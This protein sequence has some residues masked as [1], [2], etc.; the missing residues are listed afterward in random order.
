L[1]RSSAGGGRGG[2]P[3]DAIVVGAGHNGLVCATYLARAGLRTVVLERRAEAGGALANHELV[4]GA[5]VPALA[6]TV[7]R[8]RPSVVRDLDLVRHGLRLVQP[9]ARV[10][11]VRPDG[12]PITLWGDPVRTAA[13]IAPFSEHD[14]GA[15]A[16]LDRQVR[17]HAGVMDRL[18][19]MTPPDPRSPQPGVML[20]A[21]RVGLGYRSLDRSERREFVRVLPMAVLDFLGDY[22]DSDALTAAVAV[23]G[24]RF[25]SLGPRSTGSV[26]QLLAD[27]AGNGGGLAG[28]TV[29]ARGGPSSVTSALIAALVEHGGELRT[30]AE[31]SLVRE[32]DGRVAGVTLASGDELDAPLVVGAVDP[33][34]LLCDLVDPEVLG[35]H[36]GWQA[37]NLRQ[38]GVTA[39]VN[40]ALS[41]LPRF[42]GIDPEQNAVRLR[43]RILV[44]PSV[45]YLDDA[46]DVAKHGRFPTD[47]WLE[48]TI[49]SLVDPLLVDGARDSGV[50]HVMS[51]VVQSAPYQLRE[52]GPEAWDA[53]RD[54]LG[55]LVVGVLERVAPG[56]GA[57]V[58][59]R[60]VLTPLDLER[61]FGLTEGHPLHGEPSLD[62]WFAWRPMLGLAS[63]RM[64]I[65]G[66]YLAGSGAHPGGGV[67]GTPGRNAARE[68]L[69]DGGTRHRP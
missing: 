39:K 24:M 59:A 40:F 60:Q 63:Y 26:Q 66:L 35:P 69:R 14:A 17:A 54:E 45:R 33:K 56:F 7:G 15:W 32:R 8:L 52:G 61:E 49:P 16:A 4:P 18:A 44:A 5:I 36:L 27:S 67:T 65:D 43:G 30:G 68:I 53:R 58:V 48:A 20:G 62:Q 31:V 3:F 38:R 64:P 51:V 22:L 50:R 37:G 29:Y 6:H 25:S 10:T 47:P 9:Q 55:D 57:L 42:A 28:E 1:A 46:A 23:R 13:E 19:A 11:S 12:P 21:L 41:D 2:Q 34:R